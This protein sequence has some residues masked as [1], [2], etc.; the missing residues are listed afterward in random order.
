MTDDGAHTESPGDP[1]Q[2]AAASADRSDQG[3]PRV[4]QTGDDPQ[5]E[6]ALGAPIGDADRLRG[7]SGAGDG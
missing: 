6:R 2:S 4:A 1:V 7:R 3:D 5:D